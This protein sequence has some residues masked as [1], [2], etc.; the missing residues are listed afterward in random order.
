M[1]SR[2]SIYSRKIC[3]PCHVESTTSSQEDE[4]C[5][6]NRRLG[7]YRGMQRSL[8]STSEDSPEIRECLTMHD[9]IVRNDVCACE[10]LLQNG[11]NA[12]SFFV[13][14]RSHLPVAS[15]SSTSDYGMIY[16]YF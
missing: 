2:C 16:Y 10:S 9:V 3:T 8:T 13:Y 7:L 14:Y 12:N 4:L 11:F 15:S 5:Y 1:G 6:L